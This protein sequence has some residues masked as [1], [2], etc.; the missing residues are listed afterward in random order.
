MEKLFRGL[1]WF[2]GLLS[3]GGFVL[4]LRY[5]PSLLYYG[6]FF[7][8]GIPLLTLMCFGIR[9]VWSERPNLADFSLI[10][11]V[12]GL[13]IPMLQ[14]LR[15]RLDWQ[16]INWLILLWAFWTV[17]VLF[18]AKSGIVTAKY[19]KP[20]SMVF[21]C[22]YALLFILGWALLILAPLSLYATLST[23]A[24]AVN[25][26]DISLALLGAGFIVF[27]GFC[28]WVASLIFD[29]RPPGTGYI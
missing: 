12:S 28:G 29:L 16:D 23:L 15:L 6:I 3:I 1:Y 24:V 8:T 9:E 21:R 26:V 2:L 4:A 13:I 10:L 7:I 27:G 19:R 20:G 18:G 17:F 22:L 11:I 14:N 25:K 5:A